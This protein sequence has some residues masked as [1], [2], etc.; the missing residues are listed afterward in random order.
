MFSSR[1]VRHKSKIVWRAAQETGPNLSGSLS[2]QI[3]VAAYPHRSSFL[4]C[5]QVAGALREADVPP[6]CRLRPQGRGA[7]LEEGLLWHHSGYQD[8]QEG[9]GAD[10]SALSLIQYFCELLL[11]L[12]FYIL[13]TQFE[14]VPLKCSRYYAH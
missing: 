2:G 1:L 3:V 13:I 7:P 11:T 6:P 12:F 5:R 10:F 9:D 14:L 4:L 8:E